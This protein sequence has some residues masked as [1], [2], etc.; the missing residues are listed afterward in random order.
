MTDAMAQS[1]GFKDA[2]EF[3]Q[4]VA[5]ANISSEWKLA[6]FKKWQT[7]DGTK[8]GL[9]TLDCFTRYLGIPH[10]VCYHHGRGICCACGAVKEVQ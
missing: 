6:A 10:C 7:T 1:L 8:N 2:A 9:L 3:H 4:L 5:A